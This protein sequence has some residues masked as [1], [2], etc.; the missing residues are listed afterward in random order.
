MRHITLLILLVMW[1]NTTATTTKHT[2]ISPTPASVMTRLISTSSKPSSSSVVFVTDTTTSEESKTDTIGYKTREIKSSAATTLTATSVLS[3]TVLALGYSTGIKSVLLSTYISS[4]IDSSVHPTADISPTASISTASKKLT[5][6]FTN[7]LFTNTT[8]GSNFLEASMISVDQASDYTVAN[9]GLQWTTTEA[10]PNSRAI[11]TP[12]LATSISHFPSVSVSSST[13]PTNTAHKPSIGFITEILSSISSE[14]DGEA[15]DNITPVHS[16]EETTDIKTSFTIQMSSSPNSTS[17]IALKTEFPSTAISVSLTSQT[18]DNLMTQISTNSYI[19]SSYHALSFVTPITLITSADQTTRSSAVDTTGTTPLLLSSI[20]LPTSYSSTLFPKQTLTT[21]LTSITTTEQTTKSTPSYSTET[22]SSS[23]AYTTET[24]SYSIDYSTET[25]SSSIDYTAEI[26]SSS[27]DYSTE[28]TSSSIDYSTEITSSSIDYSTEITSSSIDYSTEIKSSSKDYSTEKT[29]SSIDYSTEITSSS[30]DYSTETTSSTSTY[31]TET[32]SSTPTSSTK[33]TSSIPTYTTET[34][35]STPTY[36]TETT[37]ST[38]TYSTETTCSTPTNT[39]ETTS[40]IPTY[41]TETTSSTP[42]YTTETTS[43]T[44]TYTTETSFTPINTTETTS[45]TPTYTTTNTTPTSSTKTASTTEISYPTTTDMMTSP[46]PETTTQGCIVSRWNGRMLESVPEE[47]SNL[48][49][50]CEFDTN[51][52]CGHIQWRIR[53]YDT[54]ENTTKITI[55]P[56]GYGNSIQSQMIVHRLSQND[57]GNISCHLGQRSILFN[58]TIQPLPILSISPLS[59]VIEEDEQAT[60]VCN[61]SNVNHINRTEWIFRWYHNGSEISV[62]FHNVAA[63]SSNFSSNKAASG[64]YQCKL[65]RKRSPGE[66]QVSRNSRLQ[67]YKS[68]AR[69]CEGSEVQGVY[70]DKTPAGYL[71]E[72]KCPKQTSGIA[73]RKCHADGKWGAVILVDCVGKEIDEA[74]QKL[75]SVKG[76]SDN[77]KKK[78]IGEVLGSI[79]NVTG[80]HRK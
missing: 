32:T 24:S 75:E 14:G 61:I 2:L 72:N 43:S 79:K 30:I 59:L 64:N 55:M 21:P 51:G 80:E 28:T 42:T 76:L 19:F 39:T 26:I 50:T 29:S 77:E 11:I 31:T 52:N 70:W 56:S 6:E 4:S 20:V 44:P 8:P 3:T 9:T 10:T 7:I 53:N 5:P 48:T 36:T 15:T 78:V 12:V 41:T 1:K 57:A 13:S 60:M 23:L 68:A 27:K 37:S 65:C 47:K 46:L 45:S 69:F 18:T 40:S 16:I 35:S 49:V 58:I 22:T 54:T 33:T 67:V 34:T 71:L 63:A 66:C 73:T 25:T 74:S 62:A 38:P 17:S